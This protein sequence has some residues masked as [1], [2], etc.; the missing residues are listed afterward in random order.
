MKKYSVFFNIIIVCFP[1]YA[2]IING[3]FETGNL[4]GWEINLTG[5]GPV[6]RTNMIDGSE[7]TYSNI[8]Q[9]SELSGDLF[10]RDGLPTHAKISD[11]DY[12]ATDGN[13]FLEMYGADMT[14]YKFKK[15]EYEYTWEI[16]YSIVSV[17]Q[18]VCVKAGDIISGDIRFV[19]PE[20]PNW[21]NDRAF[22]KI[23]GQSYSSI[24]KE[25]KVSDVF[26]RTPWGDSYW[27]TWSWTAPADGIY[28]LSL[29]NATD[30]QQASTSFFDNIKLNSVP[31][32]DTPFMIFLGITILLILGLKVNRKKL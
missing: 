25:I 7:Y 17:S 8:S 6:T 30:L 23:D 29:C 2:C 3:S 14:P 12:N 9:V 21:N 26:Y 11:F 10:G 19:S 32:P 13:Y 20:T 18:N 28:K 16:G 27:E 1:I 24:P 31:E 15:G 5:G 22:V 4:S